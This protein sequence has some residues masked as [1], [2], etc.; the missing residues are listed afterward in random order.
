MKPNRYFIL[1]LVTASLIALL[2][3]FASLAMTSAP[4]LLLS[5]ED[6]PASL[7]T[8]TLPELGGKVV[9]FD[10]TGCLQ[11]REYASQLILVR[12]P[13]GNNFAI[14][15]PDHG[16]KRVDISDDTV[17]TWST[18]YWGL[19]RSHVE[20]VDLSQDSRKPFPGENESSATK[21]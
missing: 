14:L 4:K 13:D 5:F 7:A 1:S 21:E 10:T 18:S 15:F 17:R 6:Q 20:Q 9:S 3:S 2:L 16:N 19:V 8:A 11:S 12:G